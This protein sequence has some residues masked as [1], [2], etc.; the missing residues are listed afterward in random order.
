MKIHY[1]SLQ[2]SG[3]A[4]KS[5]QWLVLGSVA[6]LSWEIGYY[7]IFNGF[8]FYDDEGY[9][10]ALLRESSR[11]G[12]L[13]S[14]IY[15]QYGPAFSWIWNSFYSFFN[16]NYNHDTGRL[17][18]LG[19]WILV[20][21]LMGIGVWRQTKQWCWGLIAQFATS[22]QLGFLT[23]E[24]MHPM[25]I[26]SILVALLYLT[27]TIQGYPFWR[28][29]LIGIFVTILGAIKINFGVFGF[30][31]LALCSLISLVTCS[32]RRIIRLIG[33]GAIAILLF[34]PIWLVKNQMGLAILTGLLMAGLLIVMD[35]AAKTQAK[36]SSTLSSTRLRSALG[37][38]SGVFAATVA[39]IVIAALNGTSFF[40]LLNGIILRPLRQE[41]LFS[42][43]FAFPNALIALA[44]L[45]LL[46]I[47]GLVIAPSM[48]PKLLRHDLFFAAMLLAM[49]YSIGAFA[50]L[51]FAWLAI[52]P[53]WQRETQDNTQNDTQDQIFS[54]VQTSKSE[55]QQS[56]PE[57][58]ILSML[59]FL[60]VFPIAGSQVG[61]AGL[62]LVPLGVAIV[63]NAFN[64]F[65]LSFEPLSQKRTQ[66]LLSSGLP[67]ALIFLLTLQSLMELQTVRTNYDKA[68]NLQIAGVSYVR[69]NSTQ[70][71]EL[72]NITNWINDT[73]DIFFALPG[74]NS[75]YIFTNQEVPGRATSGAWFLLL[76][77]EEQQRVVDQMNSGQYA[78]VCFI[79]NES[80]TNFWLQGKPMA[81]SPIVDYMNRNFEKVT[82]IQAN[83][84]MIKR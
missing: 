2:L 32:Q 81:D 68:E 23:T 51:P 74:Q 39:T 80:L 43:A 83:E 77:K 33:I 17:V 7:R 29:F 40:A 60:T 76:N 24:P 27:L 6:A 84:L 30:I 41:E 28:G 61:M 8:A 5:I 3:T 21:L 4:L 73:C 18:T 11:G 72:R 47:I 50:V 38:L 59:M 71:R 62:L 66:W 67:L 82:Q 69:T 36:S 46:L 54:N 45:S 78:R 35:F 64:Q 15:T 20:S 75:F 44:A 31:A 9:M 16:L 57:L 12:S 65:K 34:A 1:P 70:A 48:T 13:Y 56:I 79:K 49:M 52:F 26:L 55:N 42:L 10:L 22:S 14:E 58:P 19:C 53:H 37:W 25:G 63:A